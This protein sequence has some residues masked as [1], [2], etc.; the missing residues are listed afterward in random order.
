MTRDNNDRNDSD[1]ERVLDALSS[2]KEWYSENR[3]LFAGV[4]EVTS[5]VDMSAPEP[6]TEAHISDDEVKIVAEVRDSD[7]TQMSVGFDDGVMVCE[8]A[9]RSFQ[10]DVPEDIDKESVEATM[11]NG[12]LEVTIDRL[13]EPQNSIDVIHEEQTD[14]TVDEL[15][16]DEEEEGGDD[17]GSDE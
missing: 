3:D 9:G 13:D 5:K 14:E 7:V 11:S 17:D 16:E 4:S 1:V 15:F 10:V 12:V 2:A 8:V 6:L